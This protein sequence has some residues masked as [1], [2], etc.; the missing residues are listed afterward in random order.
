VGG[1][2]VARFEREFAQAHGVAHAVTV[3][4]GT[5]ALALGLVALGVKPGDEVIVPAFTFIA[6]A[7]AV[8]QAEQPRSSPTSSPPPRALDRGR[9]WA[10]TPHESGDP[11]HLYGHPRPMDDLLAGTGART[12]AVR[13]LRPEPLRPLG[14]AITGTPVTPAHFRS[15]HQEPG[16]GGRRGR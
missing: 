16:G 8:V 3:K 14:R 10:I 7:A 12:T 11:V 5:A 6:T 1:E 15:T 2:P 9:A 4:S 13:G